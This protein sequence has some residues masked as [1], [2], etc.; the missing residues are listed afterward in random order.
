MLRSISQI[1]AKTNFK[2]KQGYMF[3]F[4]IET[5]PPWFRKSRNSS[6]NFPICDEI[7]GKQ[8][9]ALII[10][11]FKNQCCNRYIKKREE[12]SQFPAAFWLNSEKKI[13]KSYKNWE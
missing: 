9:C 11:G 1:Y 3:V 2:K 6:P 8:G 10:K 5:F 13:L 7:A 12:K 4:E